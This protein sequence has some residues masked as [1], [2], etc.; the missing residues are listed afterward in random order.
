M[1]EKSSP[2]CFGAASVF[3]RD[4]SICQNC[5]HFDA[6]G[7]E[8]LQTLE[9]IKGVIDVSDLFKRHSAARK[10]SQ[11]ALKVADEKADAQLPPGNVQRSEPKEPVIRKTKVAQVKFEVD[12]ATGL[13]VAKLPVKSREIAIRMCKAGS[14]EELREDVKVGVNTFK[15]GG[16]AF[17]RVTVDKLL[18]GG[19]TRRSLK[20][21]F[22]SE[23][24]WSEN[25]ASSHVSISCSLLGAFELVKEVEEQFKLI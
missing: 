25:A 4:S 1:I 14:L 19:F 9:R 6:C 11:K 2:A 13:V 5:T 18:G 12:D 20:E 17:L 10:V 3:A 16:P 15:S 21:A 24:G 23:L 8:S 22:I 7:V